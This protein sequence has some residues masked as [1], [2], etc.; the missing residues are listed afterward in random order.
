MIILSHRGYWRTP[1]EKNTTPAFARS[2]QLGFGT[3]TDLRDL[4]G[5]LV[6]SHDP[7]ALGVPG[8]EVLFELHRATD[9]PLPLALNVKADGLQGMIKA[10]LERFA[11][12]DAFVFDMSIPDTRGYLKAGI[13]VFTRQSE[14]ERE[15]AFYAQAAGVWM[16]GF[17]EDWMSEADIARHLQ[18]GKRVCIVSPELHGRDHHPFWDRLAQ[19]TLAADPRLLL[20]TDR[21]E[22]AR[23]LF[24]A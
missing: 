3:E 21:P 24:H 1:A 11:P 22:D 19:L 9:A 7:P 20:C 2:F 18:R 23:S 6:I 12:P 5:R 14:H 13:P 10:M 16:D 8:A 4:A 15:P 17:Q